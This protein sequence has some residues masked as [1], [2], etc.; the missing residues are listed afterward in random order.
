VDSSPRLFRALTPTVPQWTV[1]EQPL[2]VVGVA[3]RALD[4]SGGG[5]AGARSR[6]GRWSGSINNPLGIEGLPSGYKPVQTIIFFLLFVAALST[7]VLRLR[8]ARGVER[9]QIK[10]PAYT[11]VMAASGGVLSYTLSEAIG[12]RWLEWAGFVIFIV[13]LVGFPISLGIAIVRYR[14]YDIDLLINRTLVYGALTA[15]LALIYF[16]GVTSAQAIFR[17]LPSQEQQ[18]QLAV[19][20][21]TL[22]GLVGGMSGA[23]ISHSRSERSLG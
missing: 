10:W 15:T 4:D 5:L 22:V 17:A 21:S 20:V 11:A 9:Q 3:Q 13:A 7:L 16:G 8:R 14:L 18:P 6:G 1:A 12:S 2:E 23:R 19:V